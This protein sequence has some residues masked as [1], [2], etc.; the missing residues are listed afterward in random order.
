MVI[1]HPN[2]ILF[3]QKPFVFGVAARAL[4]YMLVCVC[5]GEEKGLVEGFILLLKRR[6]LVLT[7]FFL[8]PARFHS[9]AAACP[10]QRT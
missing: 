5:A 6:G 3:K 2:L 10:V 9:S 1:P 7:V 8:S 4:W